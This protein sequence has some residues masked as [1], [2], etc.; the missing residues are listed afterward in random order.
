M[1]ENSALTPN[2]PEKENNLTICSV[3]YNSADWLRL[4]AHF[5]RSINK[6]IDYRWIVVEN[7]DIDSPKRLEA[8]NN[9]FDILAGAKRNRQDSAAPSYHHGEG[10]NL[11]VS[12]VT[13]RFL[14]ILDPDFYIILEDWIEKILAYM[15]QRDISIL[16]APWHPKKYRKWSYFPC[17]HCIFFD[18]SKIDKSSLDFR[19]D[20][21]RYPSF[22]M[23][24]SKMQKSLYKI[25]DPL[26][27]HEKRFIGNEADTGFRI[28]KRYSD[29][30]KIKNECFVP[31]YLP[32]TLRKL[33]D[34]V[35]RGQRSLIPKQPHYYSTS[36]FSNYHLPDLKKLGCE[37]FLWR[38]EPLGFHVRSFPKRNIKGALAKIY[39]EIE[40]LLEDYCKK[41]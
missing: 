20:Y 13:T 25:F 22:S 12:A 35:H 15:Q 11:G 9:G 4:N 27:L 7:S 41:R 17:A 29:D 32:T 26:K 38:E 39:V 3:S 37:E 30:P 5:V 18:L 23:H 10:L 28:Y 34:R 2:Q 16:G 24:Y 31:V 33:Q 40:K 14:L 6:Q 1:S 36:S 19:P 8:T 21:D